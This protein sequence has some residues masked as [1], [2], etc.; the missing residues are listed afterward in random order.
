VHEE[1]TRW[2]EFFRKQYVE[3]GK[4]L[5]IIE[6][7]R[8]CAIRKL[9][10]PD[11]AA[12]AFVDCYNKVMGYEVAS[13]DDVFGNPLPKGMRRAK[14]RLLKDRMTRSPAANH[15]VPPPE[16]DVRPCY[17]CLH[18]G[19]APLGFNLATPG[20]KWQRYEGGTFNRFRLVLRQRRSGPAL[21]RP[22]FP[23]RQVPS[24]IR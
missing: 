22:A 8:R 12:E 18:G 16:L 20:G 3:E 5:A 17:G 14:A 1:E 7:I 15:K 19:I 10:L 13:W 4:R 21:A 6:A 11:W 23:S 24:T 9:P 2:L